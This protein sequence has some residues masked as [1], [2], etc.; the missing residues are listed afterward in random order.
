MKDENDM[1]KPEQLV[2]RVTVTTDTRLLQPI[3]DFVKQ[4]AHRLGLQDRASEHL[5]QA[6]EVVCQN[7]IDNAFEP[8]EEGWYDVHILRRPGQV[9]VAVEDQG[10]PGDYALFESGEDSALRSM[11]H[12]SFADE[13]RFINLGRGGNRVELVKN[14]P[15]AD[16]RKH[17][18]EDEHRRTVEAH[19]VSGDVPLEIRMMRPEESAA[20]SRTVYRSYGYSYDWDDI[21]YPERIRELQESDLMRSCVVVSAGDEI[22]GHLAVMVE[23]PDSPVGEAGQAGVGPGLR[24]A[25]V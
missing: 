23:S 15:H 16:V 13:A 5:D 11:L 6:V 21:Y 18:S 1:T 19:A 20:L 17:L 8:G 9:V 7:V 24:G 22:V 3:V 2:A 4:T 12:R 14:L 10:M 25:R